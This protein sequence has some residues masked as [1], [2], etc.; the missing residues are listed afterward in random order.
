M[1][2]YGLPSKHFM[3]RP[4]RVD[5]VNH[6]IMLDTPVFRTE[7]NNRRARKS[8]LF[9][10][11][12]YSLD[13]RSVFIREKPEHRSEVINVGR[14]SFDRRHSPRPGNCD[15]ILKLGT[16]G[17]PIVSDIGCGAI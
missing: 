16:G 13:A 9:N 6:T 15:N 1:Y 3:K 8:I 4:E 14:W 17:H 10:F 7:H 5:T 2:G 11:L 12:C